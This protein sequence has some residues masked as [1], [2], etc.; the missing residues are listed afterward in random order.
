M[1]HRRK[2]VLPCFPPCDPFS[3]GHLMHKTFT[4]PR[5]LKSSTN[6]AFV[7]CL[8]VMI[9]SN[10]CSSSMY[11]QDIA[12]TH[13]LRN[14]WV[15]M[16]VYWIRNSCGTHSPR[17]Y[18]RLHMFSFIVVLNLWKRHLGWLLT[19]I[20]YAT[21]II[22]KVLLRA[23]SNLFRCRKTYTLGNMVF[24]LPSF[25]ESSICQEGVIFIAFPGRVI[26]HSLWAYSR[27]QRGCFGGGPT[28]TGD[29][30]KHWDALW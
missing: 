23:S 8:H 2:L 20:N 28:T 3:F 7:N 1:H 21:S 14:N 6:L 12:P 25:A 26:E 10:L 22:Y 11:V 4:N 30:F 18:E 29:P 24:K 17:A 16:V 27:W 15:H 19:Y 5:P 13:Q 9:T